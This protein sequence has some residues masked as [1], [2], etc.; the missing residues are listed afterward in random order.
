MS[1]FEY[2][3]YLYVAEGFTQEQ[4]FDMAVKLIT[5]TKIDE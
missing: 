5:N 1:L 3:F 4:A 2:A